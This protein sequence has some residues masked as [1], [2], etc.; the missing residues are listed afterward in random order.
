MT[1]SRFDI[2]YNNRKLHITADAG[3]GHTIA[4]IKI[5]SCRTFNCGEEASIR[6]ITVYEGQTQTLDNYEIDL[7]LIEINGLTLSQSLFF[8]YIYTDDGQAGETELIPFYDLM[9]LKRYVYNAIKDELLP[10]N[11]CE[12]VSDMVVDKVMLYFG[13]THAVELGQYRDACEFINSIYRNQVNGS[14]RCGCHG[15]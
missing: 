6:S 9:A 12:S 2:D 8:A 13:F 7:D 5:D 4:A 14:R 11:K 10:C 15:R 1:V 3:E